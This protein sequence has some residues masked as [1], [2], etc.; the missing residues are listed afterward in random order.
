MS[1][2]KP[3][4]ICACL[5]APA[6]ANAQERI[7][8]IPGETYFAQVQLVRL[9]PIQQ[10]GAKKSALSDLKRVA[11]GACQRADATFIKKSA[12][13]YDL[14]VYGSNVQY[15]ASVQCKTKKG[16]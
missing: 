11:A 4:L 8:P 5:L 13:L 6:A 10:G 14:R 2:F 7:E 15:S 12:E 3:V 1:L 16:G 9:I